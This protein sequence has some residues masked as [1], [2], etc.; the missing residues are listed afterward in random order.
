[1]QRQPY[2][3]AMIIDLPSKRRD[4]KSSFHSLCG[5]IA[6][7]SDGA[8]KTIYT[9]TMNLCFEDGKTLSADEA[10]REMG[11]NARLNIRVKDPIYHAVLSFREGEVPTFGQVDEAVRIYLG[12]LG[13]EHCHVYYGLHANTKN[14]HVHVC[15][16]RVD[17]DTQRA[18]TPA[19]GFTYKANERAARKIELVQGWEIETSGHLCGV[20][21]GIV[22]D[23]AD[24][25]DEKA[26][27]WKAKDFENYAAEKSAVR[28]AREELAGILFDEKIKDWCGLHEALAAH[29]AR[30]EKKGSGAV[31]F[32]GEIPV[33]LSSVSQKLS[34]GKLVKR[35]GAFEERCTGVEVAD[36]SPR[37]MRNTS[38]INEYIAA[39]REFYAKKRQAVEEIK[40]LR[41]EERAKLVTR[42]KEEVRALY[43]PRGT[44]RGKGDQ[45]NALR[46]VLALTHAYEKKALRE[47]FKKAQRELPGRFP[48][49]KEWEMGRGRERTA[50]LWRYRASMEGALSGD[51]FVAPRQTRTV[52]SYGTSYDGR[53]KALRYFKGDSLAFV[54]KGKRIDVFKWEDDKVIKDVLMMAQE[55]W[56]GVTL[57][58]SGQYISRC[59]EIAAENG[60]NVRNPELKEELAKIK[61]EK[62]ARR[63]WYEK[64]CKNEEQAEALSVYCNAVGAEK[65]RV[66]AKLTDENGVEARHVIGGRN[67]LYGLT[68]QQVA[69]EWDEIMKYAD[70]GDVRIAPVSGKNGY[71]MLNGMSEEALL[72][73]KEYGYAPSVVLKDESGE[74]SAVITLPKAGMDKKLYSRALNELGRSLEKQCGGKC[75]ASY[76]NAIPLGIA[77]VLNG[78][79]ENSR[80]LIVESHGGLCGKAAG[81]LRRIA[82]EIAVEERT[83]LRKM[84]R[85]SL[86]ASYAAAMSPCEV[87]M[88]H[89]HDIIKTLG[90]IDNW[91]RLDSMVA[92]RMKVTGYDRDTITEAVEKGGWDIRPDG[93]RRKLVR[94]YANRIADYVEGVSGRKAVNRYLGCRHKWLQLEGRMERGKAMDGIGL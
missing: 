63:Q 23:C 8:E 42:Q 6:G 53:E 3:E 57:H 64:S 4:G 55:K 86:E 79:K 58:G 44:W 31:L 48:S 78:S 54:D 56:G 62:E 37:P 13:M 80:A 29:G 74:F 43:G 17:P 81:E 92:V 59:L 67:G 35:L 65:Y 19:S 25:N 26:V 46:S 60:I 93:E 83:A 73:L 84:G 89:A 71:L 20:V 18:V 2:T 11:Y 39:R 16:S 66:Y 87:Y 91:N 90:S 22:V 27:C 36:V 41:A 75:S 49:Y 72:K 10:A 12:E 5:Y 68:P 51:R 28:I 40:R 50:D 70:R 82:G 77:T 88:A 61:T 1:M 32:V 45:L 14:M 52:F 21:D 94:G 30:L 24:R 47:Y 38:G 34:F 33:K 15:V 69:A 7:G 9:N 76:E 85:S